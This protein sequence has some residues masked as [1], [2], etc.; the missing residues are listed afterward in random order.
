MDGGT[1]RLP[2][3]IGLSRAMDMIITGRPVKAQEA[4][5][6]GWSCDSHVTFKYHTRFFVG[7]GVEFFNYKL[8]AGL[9]QL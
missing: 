7:R 1:A 2:V 6:M 5:Q 4:L 8:E 3:L 9:R